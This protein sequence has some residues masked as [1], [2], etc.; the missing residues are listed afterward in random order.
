MKEVSS[1][2]DD[3]TPVGVPP[4]QLS[5][6]A[7]NRPLVDAVTVHVIALRATLHGMRLLIHQLW[8]DKHA[9]STVASLHLEQSFVELSEKCLEAAADVARCRKEQGP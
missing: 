2:F 1:R 5:I 6:H 9:V 4:P 7:E 3:V 8:S